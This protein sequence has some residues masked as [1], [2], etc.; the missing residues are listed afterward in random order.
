MERGSDIGGILDREWTGLMEMGGGW[1]VVKA[2][3]C[4]E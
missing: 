3:M 1:G 2:R 4:S